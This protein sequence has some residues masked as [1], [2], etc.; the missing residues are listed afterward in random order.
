MKKF[1]RIFKRLLKQL[2]KIILDDEY[3]K[4]LKNI[5]FLI[6][7]NKELEENKKQAGINNLFLEKTP[8]KRGEIFVV[9]FGYNIGSEFRYKHYCVVLKVEGNTAIVVP[10]TS[11]N[12]NR[13]SCIK[14]GEIKKLSINKKI[15]S[16]ALL[17]QIR[18]IS[19]A[20]LIRP[21]K[22]GK[23]QFIKLN[24]SQLDIIDNELKKYLF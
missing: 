12:H 14:L 15:I 6:K 5:I 4:L 9:D 2:K 24:S 7:K 23:T 13:E 1:N 16:F 18:T 17:N 11:K 8:A 19:R 21:T 22:N 10:L 20:R 3:D